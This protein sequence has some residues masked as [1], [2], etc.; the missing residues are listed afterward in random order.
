MFDH[1]KRG[2]GSGCA[3]PGVRIIEHR[4]SETNADVLIFRRFHGASPVTD[5]IAS[6]ILED[7]EWHAQFLAK[8]A[9]V[10]N[11]H[12]ELVTRALDEAGIRYNS[13]A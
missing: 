8:S 9:S 5:A 1:E 6:T 4:G 2:I 11:E 7:E 10:L 3:I 12:H 13:K